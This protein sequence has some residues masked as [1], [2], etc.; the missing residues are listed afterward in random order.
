MSISSGLDQG[1]RVDPS[2]DE[3]L[4]A[5]LAGLGLGDEPV[6]DWWETDLNIERGFVVDLSDDADG[7][8]QQVKEA[9]ATADAVKDYLRQIGRVPLLNAAK[10][11]ELGKRIEAGLLSERK[12]VM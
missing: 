4:D 10:E 8:E 6:S 2:A 5:L 12:L 9:G 7:P 1:Y 11:I 3:L